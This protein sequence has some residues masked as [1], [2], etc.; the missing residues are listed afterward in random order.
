M[1]LL[2]PLSVLADVIPL[3]GR[4]VGM[5]LAIVSGVLAA[6]T[7][8]LAIGSGWLWYRPWLLGVIVLVVAALV[9][10]LFKRRARTPDTRAAASVPPAPVYTASPPPPPPPRMPPQA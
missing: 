6:V 1:F 5:G 10:W 2:K 7:S 4:L 8:V 9:V 3:L